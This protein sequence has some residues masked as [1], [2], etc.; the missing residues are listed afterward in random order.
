MMAINTIRMTLLLALPLPM[1]VASEPAKLTDYFPPPESKGGWRTLLP[2][3]GIPDSEQKKIIREV[4][5]V[6]W[7]K[8]AEV[9]ALN[10]KMGFD[11]GIVVIRKGWIVGEWYKGSYNRDKR[12]G[13]YSSTKSYISTCF[14]LLLDDMEKGKLPDRKKLT[15]DT[16]VCNKEWL[17]ECLPLSDPRKA[18]IT[19]RH[20]LFATS[21]IPKEGLKIPEE[22]AARSKGSIEMSLGLVEGSPWAKLTGQPGTMFNY[23][24]PGVWHLILVFNN[25]AGMDLFPYVKKRICDPIGM[26]N[27][28]WS[29][30]GGFQRRY[31]TPGGFTCSAREHARFCYLA[32]HRG[33]WAGKEIVPAGYYDWAWQGTKANPVYGAQWWLA[34]ARHKDGPQDLVQTIGNGNNSGWIIPSLDLVCTRIGDGPIPSSIKFD[35]DLVKTVGAAIER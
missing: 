29:T 35:Q 13:L 32:M 17:P 23:S 25:A 2:E 28:G 21:G 22:V 6:D 26:E 14:G 1:V 19:L 4:A 15:L 11:S 10:E 24:S 31:C 33:K 9:A 16:K 8:L 7:D 5:G 34:A 27:V 18:D 12:R 3:N 20:L 30:I